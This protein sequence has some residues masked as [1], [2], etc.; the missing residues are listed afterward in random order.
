MDGEPP[1]ARMAHD[2]L[3]A[4][5]YSRLAHHEPSQAMRD[6]SPD[7]LRAIARTVGATSM[8]W[9]VTVPP[10]PAEVVLDCRSGTATESATTAAEVRIGLHMASRLQMFGLRDHTEAC[11]ALALHLGTACRIRL[12][13]SAVARVGH[14]SDSAAGLAVITRNGRLIAYTQQFG[15][16]VGPDM[17]ASETF[18]GNALEDTHGQALCVARR[19]GLDVDILQV[20][21][22]TPFDRLSR[23]EQQ[24]VRGVCGGKTFK[25]IGAELHLSS[26]TVANTFYRIL[27]GLHVASR[28]ALV[29]RVTAEGWLD[30]PDQSS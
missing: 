21:R 2:H 6:S 26:S 11:H 14:R 30:L 10:A 20:W 1:T 25:Q 22:S 3:I 23:R 27:D 29:T 17:L 15:L 13:A 12:L 5:I 24:I 8:H 19:S 4:L 18:S 9:R 7:L 16:L 28:Q